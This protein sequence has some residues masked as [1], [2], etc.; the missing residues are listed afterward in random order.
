MLIG[1]PGVAD[2][3]V[4]GVP[5]AEYGEALVAVVARSDPLLDAEAVRAHVRQRMA[6][7]KTPREVRFVEQLP[8]DD[9]GKV[10]KRKLQ[11]SYIAE[12]AQG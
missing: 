8:R 4:F 2:C 3:A 1:M 7:Y 11:D 10:A 12:T 9:N 5:D 6:G